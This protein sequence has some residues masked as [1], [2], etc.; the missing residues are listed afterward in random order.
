[1]PDVARSARAVALYSALRFDCVVILSGARVRA[2]SQPPPRR[3]PSF[4]IFRGGNP[5]LN[6]GGA[7]LF[8]LVC[9]EVEKFFHH[10]GDIFILYDY[11]NRIVF[12]VGKQTNL[13][14]VNTNIA[15]KIT[16][17]REKFCLP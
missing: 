9:H 1:M 11:R 12:H 15:R 2:P 4:L 16:V 13:V 5:K 10:S 7:L 6:G 14:V 8:C 3:L 17:G